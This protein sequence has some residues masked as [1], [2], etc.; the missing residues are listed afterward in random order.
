M[1]TTMQLDG[2]PWVLL[3]TEQGVCRVVMPNETLEDWN[4]WMQKVAPGVELEENEHAL[5]KQA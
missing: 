3:A 4:G 1:Y 2:R 5:K